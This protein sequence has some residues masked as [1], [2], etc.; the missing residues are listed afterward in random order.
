LS[1]LL[2]FVIFVVVLMVVVVVIVV[3][4][5]LFKGSTM[6]ILVIVHA[7]SVFF[8]SFFVKQYPSE[9]SGRPFLGQNPSLAK[10]LAQCGITAR[11]SVRFYEQFC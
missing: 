3:V 1:K 11:I 7:Y 8:F 5:L 4:V 2:P 9:I 6:A 10:Q